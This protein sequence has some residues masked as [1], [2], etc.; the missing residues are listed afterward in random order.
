MPANR[1]KIQGLMERLMTNVPLEK[2][3]EQLKPKHGEA[4]PRLKHSKT[5]D[6]KSVESHWELLISF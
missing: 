6:K 2:V 3:A 5:L 4:K 1:E